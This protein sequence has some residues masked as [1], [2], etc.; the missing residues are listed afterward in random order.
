[1]WVE[2]EDNKFGEGWVCLGVVRRGQRE[3]ERE[4]ENKERK[5]E[6]KEKALNSAY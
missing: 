3:K 1:M 6:G 4:E 5:K 2:R